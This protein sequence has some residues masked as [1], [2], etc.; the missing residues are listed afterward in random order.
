MTE[1][2]ERHPSVAHFEALF[3]YAHLGD[4]QLRLISAACGEL[5]PE[6]LAVL[7]DG[8]ELAAGL[9]K[10]LEAK[11]CFVRA[12]VLRRRGDVPGNISPN[13][14]L[15]AENRELRAQVAQL[16]A[17]L[18]T[19]DAGWTESEPAGFDVIART[20]REVH[21]LTHRDSWVACADPVCRVTGRFA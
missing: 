14:Q 7:P 2:S 13:A 16:Q 6:L 8:P 19:V 21:D 17:E 18:V 5:A 20:V 10:L 15:E 1:W 4:E 11:D 9:R 3:E 12:E